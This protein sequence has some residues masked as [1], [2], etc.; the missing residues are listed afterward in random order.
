LTWFASWWRNHQPKRAEK[1]HSKSRRRKALDG[2]ATRPVT[3]LAVEN[4]VG[5]PAAPCGGRQ[6]LARER[7]RGALPSPNLSLADRKVGQ[8]HFVFIGE[9]RLCPQDQPQRVA[10]KSSAGKNQS[11]PERAR[12]GEWRLLKA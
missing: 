7:E 4:S 12:P 5:K 6:M 2:P 8:G 1:P 11:R 9:A 10:S 3:P